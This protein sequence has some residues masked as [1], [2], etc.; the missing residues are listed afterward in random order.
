MA[1]DWG[2]LAKSAVGAAIAAT[3]AVF[4]PEALPTVAA[5]STALSTLTGDLTERTINRLRAPRPPEQSPFD[6]AAD[7]A[8][9]AIAATAGENNIDDAQAERLTQALAPLLSDVNLSPER[10]TAA[11]F[12][13]GKLADAIID[14]RPRLCAALSS[15][16][17][18]LARALLSAG[19]TA[20]LAQPELLTASEAAFRAA[21]LAG[22][23][24]LPR[25]LRDFALDLQATALLEPPQ[26]RP[27]TGRAFQATSTLLDARF[28]D[29]PLVGRDDVLADFDRWR[30][31]SDGAHV[32]LIIGPGGAG[33]TRLATLACGANE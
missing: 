19:V 32:R 13:A 25:E 31:D 27:F 10:L 24:D 21:V 6:R 3:T 2:L 33:K 4:F 16:E 30:E 17:I 11:G 15:A 1:A 23:H 8:L 18:T 22:F 7:A 9:A 28:G 20:A 5:G 29:L 14:S 26:S 12:D